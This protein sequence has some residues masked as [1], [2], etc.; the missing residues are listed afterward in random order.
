VFR[1]CAVISE[2]RFRFRAETEDVLADNMP[3]TSLTHTSIATYGHVR[4][5]QS[6]RLPDMPTPE[7]EM[8]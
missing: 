7:E 2:S 4:H 6:L 8:R 1:K 3:L 5:A